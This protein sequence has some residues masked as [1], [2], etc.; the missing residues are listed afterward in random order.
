[1]NNSDT[2][3]ESSI[4]DIN[5]DKNLNSNNDNF[6]ITLI[7][8]NS[9]R[10]ISLNKFRKKKILFGR[11]TNNDIV[12]NSL[13]VSPNHGFF[14]IINGKVKIVDNSSV[15]GIFVNDNKVV[16][17]FLKDGDA[18]KIDNPIEPL[19]IGVIMIVTLGEN[20]NEWQQ[21]DMTSKDTITIG[22]NSSSDIVINHVSVPLNIANIYVQN[23]N[24]I[25]V[26]SLST[27]NI[28]VNG[29]SISNS[30]LLKNRDVILIADAKLIFDNGHIYYQLYS[31]GVEIEAVDIMKTVRVKGKKKDIS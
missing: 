2:S 1:M 12:L 5:T 27:N 6:T 24:F 3:Q 30:L 4:L 31:R 22:R 13:L 19:S 26:P 17:A 10:N 11:G 23:N 25:L 8:E 18:I 7:E 21:F 9:I 29:K 16:E 15:N 14:E 20:V 28:L